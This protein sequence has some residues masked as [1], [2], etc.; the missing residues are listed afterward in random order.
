[1]FGLRGWPPA[2]ELL[3]ALLEDGALQEDA[4]VTGLTTKA[5]VGAEAGDLPIGAAARVGFAETH[6]VAEREVEH[7]LGPGS[8]FRPPL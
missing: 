5:N 2:E 3:Q 7:V 6:H 8:R 4:A 1:L